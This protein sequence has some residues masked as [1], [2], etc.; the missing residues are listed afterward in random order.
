MKHRSWKEKS[1]RLIGYFVF[2]TWRKKNPRENFWNCDKFYSSGSPWRDRISLA[3]LDL[4]E[5][6]EIQIL[7]DKWWKSPSDTCLRNEKGKESKA[8]ALG[9][10]NIGKRMINPNQPDAD[11]THK[12][13]SFQRF[14]TLTKNK[15]T[16][17]EVKI[18]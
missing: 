13:I 4:Q 3:I 16:K 8:N 17:K 14:Y 1:F 11:L 10:S 12:E 5:K 7:Y 18:F 6:G 15:Q 9:V 2:L